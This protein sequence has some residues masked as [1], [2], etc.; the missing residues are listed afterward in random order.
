[1]H[2]SDGSHHVP[3]TLGQC[4]TTDLVTSPG[5]TITC[6]LSQLFKTDEACGALSHLCP[7]GLWRY[8]KTHSFHASTEYPR[9]AG[10]TVCFIYQN[11]KEKMLSF[12]LNHWK[13]PKA[14]DHMAIYSNLN[15]QQQLTT[16]SPP[17]Q[18]ANP[19]LQQNPSPSANLELQQ[20]PL[21]K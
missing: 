19:E 7:T 4:S 16:Q 10:E 20:K 15:T 9:Q 3:F 2:R 5:C 8:Y 11:N 13:S 6:V 1:M 21:V 14:I 12:K 17:I 18:A